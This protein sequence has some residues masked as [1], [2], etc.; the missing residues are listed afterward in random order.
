METTL[1][2]LGV[3]RVQSAKTDGKKHIWNKIR[4]TEENI[5]IN[6]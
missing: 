6:K 4:A 5:S 3:P 1:R 2:S